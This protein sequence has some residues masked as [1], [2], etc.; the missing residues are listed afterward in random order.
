MAF[1]WLRT[2][3]LRFATSM[4]L[5]TRGGKRLIWARSAAFAS[6][7]FSDAV[8]L[9]TDG[10]LGF[11]AALVLAVLVVVPLPLAAVAPEAELTPEEVV[12]PLGPVAPLGPSLSDAA[13]PVTFGEKAWAATSVHEPASATRSAL[14]TTALESPLCCFAKSTKRDLVVIFIP[15]D[16]HARD[17]AAGPVSSHVF[18]GPLRLNS[19]LLYSR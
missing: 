16:A 18:D 10:E 5:P 13:C 8:A 19:A 2:S 14:A 12:V 15:F 11:A 7:A 4:L 9:S 6:P 1:K 17:Y 3:P